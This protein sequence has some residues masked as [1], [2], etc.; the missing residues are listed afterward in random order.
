MKPNQ[1]R[2]AD[3]IARSAITKKVDTG[4]YAI[5]PKIAYIKDD[6]IFVKN[7]SQD[8]LNDISL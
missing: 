1:I 6:H 5:D 2:I 3:K 4:E 8:A 7:I